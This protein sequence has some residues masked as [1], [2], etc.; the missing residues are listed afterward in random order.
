MS[1]GTL[2][3]FLAWLEAFAHLCIWFLPCVLMLCGFDLN[4]GTAC[5]A[6]QVV[7]GQELIIDSEDSWAVGKFQVVDALEIFLSTRMISC[8][9]ALRGLASPSVPGFVVLL[10]PLQPSSCGSSWSRRVE[11]P[12][13]SR[14]AASSAASCR[15]NSCRV[16]GTGKIVEMFCGVVT[17]FLAPLGS[18]E[19]PF[20]EMHC[21]LV[22]LG[23]F[24]RGFLV[25]NNGFIYLGPGVCK[26]RPVCGVCFDLSCSRLGRVSDFVSLEFSTYFECPRIL[27]WLKA[28]HTCTCDGFFLTAAVL[29]TCSHRTRVVFFFVRRDDISP[30]VVCPQD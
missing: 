5:R 16:S 17:L 30:D 23:M 28:K 6:T 18:P 3:G 24:A 13:L 8:L 19:G 4:E 15:G 20:I 9:T 2:S 7:F 21:L 10:A 1:F 27:V 11:Y 25:T 29:V 22:W 26:S 14:C 12:W